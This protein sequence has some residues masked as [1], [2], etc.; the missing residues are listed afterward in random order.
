MKSKI[1]MPGADAELDS[2][3]ERMEIAFPVSYSLIF[4]MVK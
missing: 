1:T 4:P 3:K 2:A